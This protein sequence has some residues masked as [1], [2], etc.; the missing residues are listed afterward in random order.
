MRFCPIPSVFS[1]YGVVTGMGKTL[2]VIAGLAGPALADDPVTVLA[3]GDSLTQGYG[4]PQED[5]FVPQLRD[6]LAENSVEARIVNAGVSGDTT[7]GGAARIE[8]SL[9]EEVDAIIVALGAN[10]LLRGIQPDVARG[11]LEKILQVARTR[12]V[13]VLLVGLD[14]PGNYGADYETAFDSLYPDL[15]EKYGTLYA[16]D[17]FAGLG[18][19]KPA[20]LQRYFQQ[21]KIHPNA[22]G[23]RR[24]VEDLGPHVRRLID[25]ANQG[26]AMKKGP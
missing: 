4:L 11:N 24:I 20:E 8:W 17:F 5:G 2:A 6:W 10:D 13:E 19:G 18:D 25:A 9:T 22:D 14:A 21:D 12:A 23:V 15:A 3:F 26:Q 16:P 1:T 7:A